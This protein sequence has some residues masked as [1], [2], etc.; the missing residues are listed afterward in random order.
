MKRNLVLK[1]KEIDIKDVTQV[2]GKNAAL[3][4][5]YQK[6]TP[7]GIKIPNGFAVTAQA[8]DY[9][10]EA[11]QLKEKITEILK[12]TDIYKIKELQKST[13]IIRD[14]IKQGQFPEDLK[15]EIFKNFEE[16]K[17]EYGSRLTVA[18]RS[19]ATAE[20]MPDAS[21]AGQQE[22]YLNVKE[23][24]LLEKIKKCFA[25]LFT[26]RATFYRQEKKYN[27][28]EVKLSVGIQKMVRSDL[29]SSGVMF[30]L[31]PDSGLNKV[32]VINSI[33]GLG[34]LIVQG[35]VNPDEFI[36][37]KNGLER[38]L[39]AIISKKLGKK[40]KK[41]I[42]AKNGIKEVKT[43][44]KEK[45][46]FSL[47]NEE[48][49]ELANFG[50]KIEKHF[51]KAMDIE[52][53][54]DGLNKKIY[55]IQARP[56]T[57]HNN[58]TN[59]IEE[60]LLKEKGKIIL[61]GIAIG[62]KITSGKIRV[63]KEVSK[64]NEFKENEI[65]VTEMTD[66]DWVPIM[67]KARGI[68]TDKGGRTCHAAIISRELGIPC[69]VGTEKATKILKTGQEVT[70]DC[71]QGL[72]GY[73]YQG[74]KEFQILQHEI[75][76][77]PETQTKI[78][79]NIGSPD[80]AWQKWYLPVKGVGLAREEFIIA[81][82]IG[83]HPNALINYP[84]LP[85]NLK[86]QIDKITEG[87]K[88]KKQFYIDKLKTGIAKIA[89][90]FYPQ[91]VLVRFSDFKT[92]EYRNLLGGYL[93]EPLEENPMLGWRGASRYY[94]P[95][96]KKAFELELIAL[97]QV[98][99]E[100]GLDNIWLFVPYC[101]TPEEGKKVLEIIEKTMGPRKN[102]YQVIVMGEI[103]ANILLIDKFLEI[104]DGVSIGSNDLTQL[105]LGLDR[106][107]GIISHIANE[108]NEAVKKMIK[109][110][111]KKCK[112]KNKYIGICGQ[113]PSDYPDFTR[114]LIQESIESISL[115]PDAVIKTIYLVKKEE[116][117][118]AH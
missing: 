19:S 69:I 17:K 76:K 14:L 15:K 65:L 109:E 104:F 10:I 1:F 12:K 100:F 92:N 97:K 59:I 57:I 99:N 30:T 113:A 94:D 105:V 48:V 112:E 103:P 43:T 118:V 66:P 8:Y 34:E 87:Y 106:D 9:F 42:Y 95:K 16:L 71:S 46:S 61:S 40:D 28:F 74:K 33:F 3:G 81:N 96:F 11:N 86:K 75:K 117:K 47:S 58:Q 18:V 6:L 93:Y 5:M 64:I 37:F 108:N 60:Y 84:H 98:R 54:K 20:D 111:I 27:H 51:K 73:L 63:I 21:F 56:E 67:K 39:N 49:L 45:D 23:N 102:N 26:E 101:R 53:A 72:T 22:T 44:K 36:V 31:D 50:L 52:W 38:N 110:L 114:F 24:E 68:I 25:S 55:I 41:I 29:G 79:I 80:E 89:T 107:S 35:K 32:I 85:Q 70:L 115:N 62:N 83:I 78:M 91:P 116:N 82:E 7:L 90:A 4:E 77:I 88:D 2:G 13:K